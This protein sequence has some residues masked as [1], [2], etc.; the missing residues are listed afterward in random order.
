MH[1]TDKQF[2]AEQDMRTL[3]EAAKIKKDSKRMTAA[4]KKTRE[5]RKALSEITENSAHTTEKS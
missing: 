5:E 1:M 2:Q 4:M 3:I